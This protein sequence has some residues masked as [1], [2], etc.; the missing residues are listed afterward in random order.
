MALSLV[1]LKVVPSSLAEAIEASHVGEGHQLAVLH[2]VSG[3]PASAE[4]NNL[5]NIPDMMGHF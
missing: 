4:D 2:C 3:Y 5:R 1:V